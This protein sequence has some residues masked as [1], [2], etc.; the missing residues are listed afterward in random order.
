MRLERVARV[1]RTPSIS[2]TTYSRGDGAGAGPVIRPVTSTH[3]ASP[4]DSNSK[5]EALGIVRHR[6]SGVRCLPAAYFVGGGG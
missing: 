4:T 2:V 1:R 6:R 5:R 3:A